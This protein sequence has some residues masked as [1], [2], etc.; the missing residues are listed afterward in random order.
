MRVHYQRTALSKT[1]G[2]LR[3]GAVGDIGPLSYKLDVDFAVRRLAVIDRQ[4]RNLGL[5]SDGPRKQL[6]TVLKDDQFRALN[7]DL[8]KVNPL[9]LGKPLAESGLSPPSLS[10][11]LH[12][13][14]PDGHFHHRAGLH[15]P[16]KPIARNRHR[17]PRAGA[18]GH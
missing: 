5:D 11:S 18:G 8:E 12:R 2:Q 6:S 17:V 1:G 9:D 14:R 10:G 15:T 4:E 13:N 7:I 3:L 16:A